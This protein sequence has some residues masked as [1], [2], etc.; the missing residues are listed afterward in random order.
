[1]R[2]FRFQPKG[3]ELGRVNRTLSS[4]GRIRSDVSLTRHA[5]LPMADKPSLGRC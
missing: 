1:M 5:F 4:I 3:E 2:H